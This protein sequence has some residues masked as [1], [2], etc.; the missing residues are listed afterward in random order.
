MQDK[1][2]K[3]IVAG[4]R[5]MKDFV[6]LASELDYMFQNIA[7]KDIEIVSGAQQ[8]VT[9]RS[10]DK[11]EKYGAD[12]LGELYAKTRG[13]QIK[14]FPADWGKHGKKAGPI[15]NEEMAKY[16]THLIAFP[17]QESRGTRN[18]IKLAKDHG[19]KVHVC[20]LG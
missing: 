4:C 3:I 2:Y 19:L 17:S 15:R 13:L 7:L 12:Y 11:Y 1:P 6:L 16:G 20:E 14:R 18:M 5:N 8:T 10:K 9:Q